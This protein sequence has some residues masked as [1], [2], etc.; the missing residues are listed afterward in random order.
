MGCSLLSWYYVVNMIRLSPHTF[1]SP[2]FSHPNLTGTNSVTYSLV[3]NNNRVPDQIQL[4]V[5]FSGNG[6]LHW[7]N[8]FYI[9]G[10]DFYGFNSGGSNID[11]NVTDVFVFGVN[12][13][14]TT[15]IQIKLFWF[16]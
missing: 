14:T 9:D 12:A 7:R 13:G 4:F 15:D 6:F 3:H 8:D 5:E 1:K 11:P 2:I 10:P 16:S